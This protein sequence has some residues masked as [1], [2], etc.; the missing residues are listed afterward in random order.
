MF[1]QARTHLD[2]V[3]LIDH[4]NGLVHGNIDARAHSTRAMQKEL[5]RVAHVV[6][7]VDEQVELGRELLR[8]ARLHTRLTKIGRRDLL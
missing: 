2:Q 4:S 8:G 3:E 1:F 6:R 5:E 7:L